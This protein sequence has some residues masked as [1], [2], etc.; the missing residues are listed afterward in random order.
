MDISF[1]CQKCGQSLTI[2]ETEAG[3][4]VECPKCTA[5]ITVPSSDNQSQNSPV[6]P[7]SQASTCPSCGSA[8]HSGF[9]ICTT[10]GLDLRT[11]KHWQATGIDAATAPAPQTAPAVSR[12]EG[13]EPEAFGDHRPKLKFKQ[14]YQEPADV[15]I[16]RSIQ[17]E[18]TPRLSRRSPIPT[19]IITLSLLAVIAAIGLAIV[20]KKIAGPRVERLK[21]E[22]SH[23]EIERSYAEGTAILAGTHTPTMRSSRKSPTL[24]SQCRPAAPIPAPTPPNTPPAPTHGTAPGRP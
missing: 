16:N 14:P 3:T 24:S 11:G 8:I 13:E 5:S 10:C 20:G 23:A 6:E 15:S 19:K 17:T 22:R 7:S 21:V 2:D 18:A 12:N 4:I 1:S 9:A